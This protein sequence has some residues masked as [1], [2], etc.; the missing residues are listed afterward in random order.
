VNQV[1]SLSHK[2]TYCN[3][4]GMYYG[5]EVPYLHTT[6]VSIEIPQ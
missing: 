6:R 2:N 3:F 5:I 4:I 1:K